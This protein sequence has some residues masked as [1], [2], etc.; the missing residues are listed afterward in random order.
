MTRAHLKDAPWL[1]QIIEPEGWN[2]RN[3][4]RLNQEGTKPTTL[5]LF[6]PLID[7]SAAPDTV[8]TTMSFCQDS[9]GDLGMTWAHL[10]VDMPAGNR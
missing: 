8:L 6:G 3:N 9:F 10:D 2:A 1:L 7:S 5:Y 4:N